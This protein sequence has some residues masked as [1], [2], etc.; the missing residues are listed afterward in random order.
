VATNRSIRKTSKPKATPAKGKAAKPDPVKKGRKAYVSQA[1]VPRYPISEALRVAKAIADEYGKQPTR[2][3]DVAAAMGLAPGTGKF[4]MLTGA[5]I[6]YGLTE[7]GGQADE[8]ALTDLGMRVVA[9]TEEGD[10]ET[11]KREALLQPRVVRE[12]LEK[13]DG[14]KLPR[15][16][17]GKNVLEQMGVTAAATERTLGLI[18]DSADELGLLTEIKGDRYV[19][20]KAVPKPKEQDADLLYDE[21]AES[22]EDAAPPEGL[23]SADVAAAARIAHVEVPPTAVTTKTNRRV[24]ISHG[25]NKKV[26]TQLKELLSYGDFEPVVSVERE[27]TSKPVPDKVMDDMRSCGAG[28]IHV[29]TERRVRDEDGSEYQ[30][31]NQNVLIEIGA[32]MA[33]YQGRFI[34]LVEKGTTLPSNLQGLYEVRFEGDGLDHD[35]TMKLLKAFNDFKG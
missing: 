9:P 3:L 14:S 13:Y 21:G 32:A 6:A 4:K 28:I 20:L 33:L 35:A 8:I 15:E 18:I 31:L 27:T 34:L 5:S 26:V 23:S 30:M 22:D 11:A 7:G 16:N 10:D 19:N 1:D 17:I 29:G 24:F 2:P 12:F 25:K